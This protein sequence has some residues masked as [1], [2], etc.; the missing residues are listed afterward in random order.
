MKSRRAGGLTE[1]V[2]EIICAAGQVG[3]KMT[4]I[5]NVVVDEE[6]LPRDWEPSTL[7]PIYMGKG[8]PL[9]CGA[10]RAIKLLE[11]GDEGI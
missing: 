2:G 4:E 11:H 9:E 3:V 8:D 1:L 6:K 5:C 10:R 7:L